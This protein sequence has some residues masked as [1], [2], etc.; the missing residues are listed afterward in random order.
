MKTQKKTFQFKISLVDNIK[1]LVLL[2]RPYY[3]HFLNT[4]VKV[5]EIG[6]MTLDFKKPTRTE[7]QLRY[8]W[9]I[10]GLISEYTGNTEEELHEALMILKFG[11]KEVKLGKDLVNVRQSISN[12]ARFEKQKMAELIEFALEKAQELEIRVPT[13]Q[14]LGYS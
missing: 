6:T 7:Q 9:V 3:Q 10:V 14:E 4:K 5:G 11:T 8:Y 13:R 2:S 1:T 12:S